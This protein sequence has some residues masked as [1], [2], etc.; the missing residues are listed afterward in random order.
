MATKVLA[1]SCT[2]PIRVYGVVLLLDG[3]VCVSHVCC[4]PA[5]AEGCSTVHVQV[6][7]LSLERL[8]LWW[9]VSRYK[10]T[11][12]FVAYVRISFTWRKILS[13]QRS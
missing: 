3:A 7:R 10:H 2:R 4:A 1:C 6:L 5:A 9:N 8:Q 13:Y 12:G 11:F